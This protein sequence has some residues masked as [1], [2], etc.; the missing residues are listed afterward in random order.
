VIDKVQDSRQFQGYSVLQLPPGPE[1]SQETSAWIVQGL[2][3]AMPPDEVEAKL[4]GRA[5][6]YLRAALEANAR[7][8]ATHLT[9]AIKVDRDAVRRSFEDAARD[10]KFDRVG[11]TQM[12]VTPPPSWKRG[13]LDAYLEDGK[14]RVD[15][16]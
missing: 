2:E 4:A 3:R 16:R 13:S 11:P 9:L 10:S 6:E 12:R 8:L 15:L 5:R 14:W 1:L 7:F